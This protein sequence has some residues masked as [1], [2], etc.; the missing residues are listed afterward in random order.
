MYK[1]VRKNDGKKMFSESFKFI[2]Y[3]ETGRGKS[4]EDNI[5]IDSSLVLPPYNKYFTWITSPITKI[6]EN[7][8]DI[9]HFKT[10]NSE[11]II[12]KEDDDN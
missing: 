8:G 6:I 11:Y 10:N 12:T 1:I 3:D 9:I 4:L 5:E 7:T 2:T